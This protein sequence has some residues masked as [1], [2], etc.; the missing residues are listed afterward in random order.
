MHPFKYTVQFFLT[1][2]YNDHHHHYLNSRKMS[3][4]SKEAPYLLAV[5][6]Y[7]LAT[8]SQAT[9]DLISA[10]QICLFWHFI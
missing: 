3:L 1:V 2:L 10:S 4:H 6:L 7:S 5:T 8:Q 9:T